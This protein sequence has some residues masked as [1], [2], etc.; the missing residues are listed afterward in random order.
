MFALIFDLKLDELKKHYPE[1]YTKAYDEIRQELEKLG[2][3]WTKG[4]VY[5][6]DIDSKNNLVMIYNAIDKLSTLD[7]FKVRKAHSFRCGMD[8]TQNIEI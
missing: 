7:Y 3:K 1:P 4:N 5:M 2:F 8:S 6:T